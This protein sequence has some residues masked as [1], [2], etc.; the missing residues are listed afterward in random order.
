MMKKSSMCLVV[1]GMGN[2]ILAG[3]FETFIHEFSTFRIRTGQIACKICLQL[4]LV[5]TSFMK[6]S[7]ACSKSMS[8]KSRVVQLISVASR[9]MLV[10]V[11]DSVAYNP[12]IRRLQSK[13]PLFTWLHQFRSPNQIT[14]LTALAV[15]L[16]F[17]KPPEI[18]EAQKPTPDTYAR[19]VYCNANSRTQQPP[20]LHGPRFRAGR[21]EQEQ[22]RYAA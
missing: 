8:R 4:L 9:W 10:I 16:A 11:G 7:P 15:V 20:Q 12:T 17:C 14:Y 6:A 3:S 18:V 13:V 2:K 19:Y 21:R 5:S 22:G 1:R